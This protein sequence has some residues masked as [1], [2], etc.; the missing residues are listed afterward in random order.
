MMQKREFNAAE[1]QSSFLER[2]DL[3]FGM[4]QVEEKAD[5]ME[6]AVSQDSKGNYIHLWKVW[7]LVGLGQI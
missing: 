2:K 4:L 6:Q 1:G 5:A 7:I 3:K